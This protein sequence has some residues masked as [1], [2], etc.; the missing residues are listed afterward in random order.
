M[1]G[2][3]KS[4]R[5]I[6]KRRCVVDRRTEVAGRAGSVPD[7]ERVIATVPLQ[8]LMPEANRIAVRCGNCSALCGLPTLGGSE[9]EPPRPKTRGPLDAIEPHIDVA[10]GVVAVLCDDV[11]SRARQERHCQFPDSKIEVL[12]PRAI[13][14]QVHRIKVID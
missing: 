4:C 8:A 12:N 7:F 5:A 2:D 1:V 6:D 9:I 14:A 13:T 3:H 11:W 10:L